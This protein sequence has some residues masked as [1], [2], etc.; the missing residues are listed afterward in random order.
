[1]LRRRAGSHAAGLGVAGFALGVALALAPGVGAQVTSNVPDVLARREGLWLAPLPRAAQIYATTC[2]GC[3]GEMGR[4]ADEIPV[5]ANR[6]G[7]FARTPAGRRYL[8]EVPNVAL[9]PRTDAEIALVMN[10]LLENYSRGEL[11]RDFVPYSEEEV[12][13]LRMARIDVARTRAQVVSDLVARRLLPSA[14]LLALPATR[15]Y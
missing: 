10:W 8:V 1:M 11:P 2:A 6:V 12:R 15:S 9:S 3:H 7:Y 5:L 4:S 13:D 14:D